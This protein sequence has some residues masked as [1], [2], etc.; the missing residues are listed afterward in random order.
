LVDF[1]SSQSSD[2]NGSSIPHNLEDFSWRNFGDINLEIGISVIPSPSIEPANESE[3]IE[4]SQVGHTGIEEGAEHVYLGSSDIR[5]VL[6]VDSVF[7]EPIVDVG[8]EVDVVTEVSGPGRGHEE[9][10]FIGD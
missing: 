7:L 6:V 5:L 8:F 2:K 1:R 9:A 3:G 4:T 10:V